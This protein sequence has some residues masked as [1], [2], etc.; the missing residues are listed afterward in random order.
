M[1]ERQVAEKSPFVVTKDILKEDLRKIGVTPGMVL[2]VHS[3]LSSIGWVCGGPVTVIQALMETVTD[4]GTIVMPTHS[5]DY[6][7]PA[8]WMNPP[9]PREWQ[10]TIRRTMPAFDP[11]LTPSRGMGKIP[12][13]F[14]T[15]PSVLRSNHPAVSFA[16]WGKHARHITENH[17]LE[18]GLGEHSPLARIYELDGSVLLLGV[19]YERN[20]SF[21]LAECRLPRPKLTMEGAPVVEHGQRVW[22]TYQDVDYDNECFHRL[23]LDFEKQHVVNIGR[24]GI[25]RSRLFKQR[26]CVDFALKWL[27]VRH[28]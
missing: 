18:F 27:S 8:K 4:E 6:S 24:I 12:E 14:R 5:S 23:G 26:P 10:E 2:I 19:G 17:S 11:E 25:A 3:S 20:T 1:G 13:C 7:D 15:F 22:K 28:N 21:H 9:V 16:A